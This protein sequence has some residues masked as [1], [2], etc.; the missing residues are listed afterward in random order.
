MNEKDI[1]SSKKIISKFLLNM[2]P[3][4]NNLKE[5]K[6][7]VN[8]LSK[9]EWE[10]LIGLMLGDASLQTQNNGKTYRMKFERGGKNKK[11][12]WVCSFINQWMNIESAS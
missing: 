9:E 3:N 11:N 4:N 2:S 7:T 1:I 12:F 8:N 10:I 6:I 5:Y